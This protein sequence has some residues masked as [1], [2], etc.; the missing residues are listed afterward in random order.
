MTLPASQSPQLTPQNLRELEA[1]RWSLRKIRRAVSTARFEGFTVAI[2]GGLTAVCGIPSIGVILMGLV[3]TAIGVVEIVGGNRL[4]RLD[5]TAARILTFNQLLLALLI[6][7]YALWN[8]HAE[9]VHPL[10]QIN[11]ADAQILGVS[12][13]P[14]FD[15]T[16]EVL[17]VVYLSLILAALIE[18]SMALYYHRRGAFLRRYLA[19]TPQW[20][21]SMQKAGVSL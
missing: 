4:R 5:L 11:S 16:H 12:D 9:M 17:I 14:V 13:A 6:L 2:F 8:L 18:A 21:V 15:L 20:I 7:I 19:E 3:L 1:A 10:A